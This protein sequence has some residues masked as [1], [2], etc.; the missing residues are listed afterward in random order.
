MTDRTTTFPSMTLEQWRRRTEWPMTAAA[1][2]F[3]VVYSYQVLARPENTMPTEIVMNVIWALFVVDYVV[4]LVLAENR[5]L[6]FFRHLFDLASVVLP[7]LRPLRLLRLFMVL[8]MLNRTSGMALRGRITVYVIG[9]VSMM[10]YV[11]S[12]AIYDVERYAP[13]RQIDDFGDAV[14]W[15][16]VTMTT[17]GYGDYAPVTWQGRLI[18]AA[19]MLG[20]ITL[21]GVVSA[22]VASWIMERVAVGN[23]A[24]LAKQLQAG[25][26]RE[27]DEDSRHDDER[28][29]RLE[30]K[31]DMLAS[32]LAEA[33]KALSEERARGDSRDGGSLRD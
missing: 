17:V 5:Q 21:I 15:S 22:M 25:V 3:L 10:I 30:A 13:H 11:G 23:Q 19:L 32:Q 24:N 6:W 18:A 2:V 8:K 1:V 16:F 14:W 31:I 26:N 29:A 7:V 12:L 28:A 33:Q 9:A 4:S 27:L 20:G